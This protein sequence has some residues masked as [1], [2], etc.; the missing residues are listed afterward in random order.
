M[1]TRLSP[2]YSGFVQKKGEGV[3]PYS[4]SEL[5]E[6]GEDI[7]FLSYVK[8]SR[9]YGWIL[10]TTVSIK[11]LE[12]NIQKE[13]LD[14]IANVR[15]GQNGYIFIDNWQGVVLEH[16]TQPELVGTNIW[17]YQDSDG[18]KVVQNLIRAAQTVDGGYVYYSWRKP[19]SG[20]E[21]PKVSFSKGVRDWQW[22]IGTGRVYR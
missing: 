10:G 7:P 2:I 13:L 18:V 3:Y 8:L 9:E 16:G 21:R 14:D 1:I 15:Y 20:E 5:G 22:M 4:W 6:K 17:D 11:E 12:N 19:D